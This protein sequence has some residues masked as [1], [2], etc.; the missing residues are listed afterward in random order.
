MNKADVKT[1][2]DELRKDVSYPNVDIDPLYG[3]GL[4]DFP[5]RKF[6]RKEVIVNHLRWQCLQLNGDIDENQ[7]TEEIAVLR[8]KRVVMI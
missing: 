3:C 2:I 4:P 8:R 1:V 6:V 5:D 7:L